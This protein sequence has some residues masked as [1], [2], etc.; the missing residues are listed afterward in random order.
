MVNIITYWFNDWCGNLGPFYAFMLHES[1][2]KNITIPFD[3][4][5]FTDSTNRL[6]IPTIEFTPKFK[7]N[8]NKF[9]VFDPKYGLQGKVLI[10]DL[11]LLILKNID[12]IV[13][14]SEE[15][16][17]CEGAY[18]SNKAGGSIVGTTIDYGYRYI[19]KPLIDSPNKVTLMTGGSERMFYRLYLNNIKFF[20]DKYPGIYSY[21]KDVKDDQ[22]PKD[23]RILRWHGD[24][25]P[26]KTTL[27]RKLVSY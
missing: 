8:L 1:L 22:M 23:T 3:F 27:Y 14:F 19:W 7:W 15:F 25:R 10:L 9:E 21:K 16:I 5:C 18:C 11:D 24:P 12:D 13:N 20:Q 17:T 6:S 4:N 2:K 26:H